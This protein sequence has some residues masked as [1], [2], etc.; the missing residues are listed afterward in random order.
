[1]GKI[2][3]STIQ[4][5]MDRT[6]IVAVVGE[7]VRL[8]RAGKEY[9]GLCPFHGER[10]PSFFVVPEKGIFYCFGCG[11]GGDAARFLMEFEKLSYPEAIRELGAKAGVV[12]EQGLP[13]LSDGADRERNDLFEL[14]DRLSQTFAWMLETQSAASQARELLL[15]RGIGDEVRK[16]FRLGYAPSDHSWLAGFLG[17]KGYS[18]AFLA[19]SGLFSSRNPEWPLFADRLVFPIMDSRGRCVSFGGRLLNGD[20]PKYLNGPETPIYRKQDNLFAFDRAKDT[21]RASNRAIICEGYMDAISFHAA[22]IKDAVAPLGTAFTDRQA[23]LVRRLAEVAVF[24]LDADEAGQNAIA[25]S[26]P[27]AIRAGIDPR[28]ALLPGGKDPSEILE[29]E[30][31]EA[32]HKVMEFTINAGDF[33]VRRAR[34]LFDVSTL[35]GKAKAVDFFMP[36]GEAFESEIKRDSFF[37]ITARALLVSPS[38]LRADFVN[39]R[40][41]AASGTPLPQNRDEQVR[42]SREL[43]LMLAVAVHGSF[44]Q[45]V[46]SQLKLEDIE[47]RRAREVFIA[48]E[49]CFR[50][51]TMDVANI[52]E[53]IGAP[54]LRAALLEAT[55]SGE[56]DE[57]PERLVE[58]GLANARKRGLE[59]RLGRILER[60]GEGGVAEIQELLTEKMHLDE[61]L[62]KLK[63]ERDERP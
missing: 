45:K 49:E 62:A 20:G 16:D 24:A 60:L 1:M 51:E 63:D 54:E 22:G 3:E 10:T 29:N 53:R 13:E 7:H 8:T 46:R 30:G 52:A 15:K 34:L 17:K 59:K 2:P 18:P 14:Y 25:R 33:L 19:S 37:E 38:S 50:A 42:R 26:L 48:L 57:R 58:D 44:F 4:A 9:K 56:F 21:I 55:A 43:T 40:R 61:E 12:V 31:P 32:L 5:V 23:K 11:K 27:V 6:D 35:E 36:Y 41:S 39:K 28:V 47:D